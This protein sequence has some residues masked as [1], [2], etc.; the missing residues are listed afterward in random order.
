[1]RNEQEPTPAC[2]CD[3][4]EAAR[5]SSLPQV[6]LGSLGL[7]FVSVAAVLLLVSIVGERLGLLEAALARVPAWLAFLLVGVGGYPIYRGLIRDLRRGKVTAHAVMGLGLGAALAVGEYAT[8]VVIVFFMRAGE[9]IERFT[10]ERSRA[11]IRALTEAAPE[12]ATVRRN[13][14]EQVVRAGEV[15]PGDLVVVRPGQRV[16]VDGVVVEGRAEVN[17][18]PLTGESA[19]VSKQPGDRVFAASVNQLG[20]LEVRAEQ[21]G[22]D[23][24]FGRILRLV[25]EAQASKAPVQRLADKFSAY[26]IPLVLLAA[27]LTYLTTGRVMN[28]VAVLVVACACAIAIA[29]PMAVAAAV[30]AG[31]RRGILIK[32]GAYLEALARVDTLLVDKTGTLTFGAPAVTDVVPL[33]G[34]SPEN[35]MRVAAA[36]ERYSEHPLARAIVAAASSGDAPTPAQDFEVVAGRGVAARVEGQWVRVGTAEWVAAPPAAQAEAAALHAEGKSAVFVGVEDE[37]TGVVGL[38]DRVRPEVAEAFARLRQLNINRIVMVTGDTER[39]AASLAQMLGIDYVAGALPAEKMALLQKLQQ[40]GRRVAMVGDGINDAP[41]LAAADVGIAMGAAGTAA[42]IEAADIALMTDDWRQVPAAVRLARRTF[43]TIKQNLVLTAAY[44]AVGIGLACV[45]IL[46]PIAAAAAQSLP[47]VA[48][49]L[50][51]SRLLR[52]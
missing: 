48:I 44:N 33:N 18:A 51:S 12:T 21:V 37:V 14:Q 50:N 20:Y 30:G 7:V 17:Q 36:V 5:R 1:M 11:A 52:C 4:A 31:A 13:G 28:A 22:C 26:F 27:G 32:G 47:D 46:P 39:V 41:A 25:E 35:V 6:K 19:P 40:E 43:R 24:T 9:Y 3:P 23:S 15:Q 16:P 34:W 42:A 29:T 49:L 45:G 2:A 38:A 10:V 8:A